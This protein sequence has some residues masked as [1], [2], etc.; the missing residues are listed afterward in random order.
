MTPQFDSWNEFWKFLGYGTT[1]AIGF[2]KWWRVGSDEEDRVLSEAA[3]ELIAGVSDADVVNKIANETNLN[4]REQMTVEEAE[5]WNR[6]R[7]LR[8]F[9]RRN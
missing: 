2:A 5:S 9:R 8:R 3:D 6:E 4:I 1:F 7:E